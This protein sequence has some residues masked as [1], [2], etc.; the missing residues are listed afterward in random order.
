VAIQDPVEIILSK[1]RILTR[2]EK[3]TDGKDHI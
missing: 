3:K 2:V 1:G